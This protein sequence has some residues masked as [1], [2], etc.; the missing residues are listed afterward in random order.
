MPLAS[1]GPRL[2]EL[3]PALRVDVP[4]MCE[5]LLEQIA[6]PAF[7]PDDDAIEAFL[8]LEAIMIEQHGVIELAR[9]CLRRQRLDYAGKGAT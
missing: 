4:L 2:A 5:D 7:G 1:C 3:A 9:E 8:R 6:L